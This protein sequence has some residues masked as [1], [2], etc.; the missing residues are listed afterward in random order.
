MSDPAVDADDVRHVAELARIE[1]DDREIE[2]FR[3]EF[4]EIL[5][6]F[7]RLEEVPDVDAEGELENV[8]RA[9]EVTPSLPQEE[10]MRNAD[11]REDGYFKGPPVG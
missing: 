9:D 7:D 1:L 3:E 4:V 10:A 6:Y 2:R 8:L 11:E 5:E